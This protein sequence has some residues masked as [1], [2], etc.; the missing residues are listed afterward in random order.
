MS[1]QLQQALGVSETLATVADVVSDPCLPQVINDSVRLY[2]AFEA[3]KSATP[4]PA[5]PTKPSAGIGLCKIQK[6]LRAAVY[7]AEHPWVVPAI[8]A[9][10][11]G[12]FI[13]IGY[14]IGRKSARR[15]SA[16]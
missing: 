10:L 5:I 12:G 9:S 8:A 11:V 7:A 6:P 1:Y 16:T 15:K 4:A 14:T 3:M 2:S 13:L